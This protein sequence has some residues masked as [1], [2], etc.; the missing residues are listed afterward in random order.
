MSFRKLQVCN[1]HSEN[2]WPIWVR[3]TNKHAALTHCETCPSP[4]LL[5]LLICICSCTFR[6][7]KRRNRTIQHA[8]KA[9]TPLPPAELH[10]SSK[11]RATLPIFAVEKPA[12]WTP[13]SPGQ[14]SLRDCRSPVGH[15]GARHQTAGVCM[16]APAQPAEGGSGRVRGSPAKRT[17]WP[18]PPS[19]R[20]RRI[21][22]PGGEPREGSPGTQRQ[23]RATEGRAASEESTRGRRHPTVVRQASD[24]SRPR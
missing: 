6:I 3:V 24:Q 5:G 9:S 2:D 13:R 18:K 14:S 21:R 8:T 4:L 17:D 19:H 22:S 23:R 20:A 10:R 12:H 15:G 16:T 11:H 7:S 1:M